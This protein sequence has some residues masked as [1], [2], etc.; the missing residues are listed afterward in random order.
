VYQGVPYQSYNNPNATVYVVVG[1]AGNRE[2]LMG[3]FSPEPW[4]V[5]Q[6][7]TFGY[8]LLQ[9]SSSSLSLSL[10]AS[11]DASL[12]DNFVITKTPSS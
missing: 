2:G 1:M 8:T 6:V 9:A 11:E 3:S 5:K 10:Y 7:S 12:L 4:S